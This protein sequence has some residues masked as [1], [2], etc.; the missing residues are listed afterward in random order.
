MLSEAPAGPGGRRGGDRRDLVPARRRDGHRAARQC[1]ERRLRARAVVRARGAGAARRRG[2]HSLGEAYDVAA[3]LGGGPA[4]PALR[5]AARHSFVHGLHVTLLVSAG[6]LLLRRVRGAAAAAGDG[7]RGPRAGRHPAGP[8]P[9]DRRRGPRAAHRR[10]A[11]PGD[12]RR[13]SAARS[14]RAGELDGPG[15]G[16]AGRG[17]VASGGSLT[18]GASFQVRRRQPPCPRPSKLPPF[19]PADPLGLDDLLTPEDLAIRDTVRDLGRRPGAAARRRVVRARRAARH[20]RAR[21]R[22]RR[23]SARSA[24]R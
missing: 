10:R 5:H 8:R 4:G 13:R 16:R 2:G 11:G 14:G 20:P 17:A 24:C 21:P 18:S 3:R 9:P 6:L 7:V 15:P 1:D 23:A 22:T 12:A 19:D